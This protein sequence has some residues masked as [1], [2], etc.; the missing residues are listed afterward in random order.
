[1][2]IGLFLIFAFSV[3]ATAVAIVL[4]DV[5]AGGGE[6]RDTKVWSGEPIDQ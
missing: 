2:V 5:S 1:M 4:T 3:M 6:P